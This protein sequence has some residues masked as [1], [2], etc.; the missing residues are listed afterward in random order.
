MAVEEP[1]VE[2][3]GRRR[4]VHRRRHRI[5]AR[6]GVVARI[7]RCQQCAVIEVGARAALPLPIVGRFDRKVRIDLI[8]GVDA[9][10][11]DGLEA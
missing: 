3:R 5:R 4:I 1:V 9:L 6:V 10:E 7:N 2:N 8:R 11:R